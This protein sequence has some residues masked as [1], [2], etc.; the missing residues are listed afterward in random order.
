MDRIYQIFN[1]DLK[2]L[3]PIV[4]TELDFWL[5]FLIMMVVF[6]LLQKQKLVRSI[7]ITVVSLFFYFKSA[8]LFVLFLIFSMFWNFAIGNWISKAK[9]E[10]NRKTA[11]ILGISLN[12]LLLVYFKYG[13]FFT[14]SFNK[15]FQTDFELLNQ[16]AIWGNGFFREGSFETK[17]FAAGGVSFIT[18]QSISYIVDVYRKEV[19]PVK[20]VFDY[21]FYATFFPQLI[22]GPI[23]KAKDFIPQI[24]KPY[25]LDKI[26]FSWASIQIIKGLI[27]KLI[28]AD[29]IAVHFID[30]VMDAPETYP[31]FVGLV[32]MWAYS[33]F[34]YGD[35]SGYTDIATGIARLMGFRLTK[36]FDS[37]YKAISV[38]DFWRRWHRSLGAFFREYLYIPLGG[39]KTG[40]IGSYIMIIV[41]LTFLIFITQNFNLIYVYL[42]ITALYLILLYLIPNFKKFVH[43]DL[44]LLI[45]MII[46]GLWHGPSENFV[47]WGTMNGIALVIFNYWKKISPYEKSEKWIT[48][49]WKIFITFNFI[50]FTRIWFLIQ[51]DEKPYKFLEHIFTKFQ[52]STEVFS[53]FFMAFM[54]ALIIVILG[55]TLHWLPQTWKNKLEEKYTRLHIVGQIFVVALIVILVYQAITDTSRPFVYLQF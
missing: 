6:S 19:E 7:F 39:N 35:F 12:I 52:F 46:G 30:K 55:F 4:F 24:Y 50:T 10:K 11:L 48:R 41:I 29:Y 3:K 14:E 5:F 26:D 37:P 53:K 43:R 18:F 13:F 28:L 44:N 36:N 40:G 47:I 17:L 23:A 54:P 32:A 51:E 9:I 42:G 8:K 49:F 25:Y 15:L 33:L 22:L 34:I 31:G 45:T 21:T 38:A 2:S 16:F 27:K 20:N 1:F